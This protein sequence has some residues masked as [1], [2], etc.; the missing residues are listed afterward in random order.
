MEQWT[1]ALTS[2]LAGAIVGALLTQHLTDRTMRSQRREDFAVQG[3][4]EMARVGARVISILRSYKRTTVENRLANIVC[5]EQDV[6]DLTKI[7]SELWAAMVIVRQSAEKELVTTAEM[8]VLEAEAVRQGLETFV[9]GGGSMSSDRG[10]K[11]E[12]TLKTLI[13]V[14]AESTHC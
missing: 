1:I 9:A 10:D 2:G 8:L 11:F 3:V 6:L 12:E 4:A 13:K 5:V 14:A 7:T